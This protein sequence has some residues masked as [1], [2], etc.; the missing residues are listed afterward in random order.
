MPLH[1][2]SFFQKSFLL[3]ISSVNVTKSDLVIFT[4]EILHGKNHFLYSVPMHLY[5][6]MQ[7]LHHCAKRAKI[8]SQK[9]LGANSY[10][11]RSYG[12]KTGRGTFLALPLSW[13]GLRRSHSEMF[14]KIGALKSFAI[15]R[16][17]HLCWSLFLIKLQVFFTEHFGW[18]PLLF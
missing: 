5:F 6:P 16:G 17:K 15:F 11:C 9:V 10:V 2:K 12:G 8:K 18:L 4:D 3:R 1:K 14:F 13:I 7:T